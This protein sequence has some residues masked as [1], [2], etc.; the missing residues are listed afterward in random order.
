M[1]MVVYMAQNKSTADKIKDLLSREG[2][3]VK[4][5]PVYKRV[6]SKDNYYEILVPQSEASEVH[7][8]LME[9]GF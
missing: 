3:L 1:W 4:L 6:S 7:D 2:F 9:Q 8:I 5:K